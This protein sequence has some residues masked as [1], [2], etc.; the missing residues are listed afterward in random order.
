MPQP[1]SIVLQ[2]PSTIFAGHEMTL[3]A[4]LRTSGVR[5][6]RLPRARIVGRPGRHRADTASAK[7]DTEWTRHDLK[8]R[9]DPSAHS[10]VIIAAVDGPGTAWFDHLTLAVDGKPIDALPTGTDPSPAELAAIGAAVTPLRT[11]RA[12]AAGGSGAGR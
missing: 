10:L 3:S 6:A 1:Q 7:G 4:W 12:P 11:V 8:I 5:R 2:V 9:V